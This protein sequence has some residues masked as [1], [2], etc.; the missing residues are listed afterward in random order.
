MFRQL[1]LWR[2]AMKRTIGILVLVLA[3]AGNA[4][5]QEAPA[6]LVAKVKQ[7]LARILSVDADKIEIAGVGK[8]RW[9]DTSL[10]YQEKGLSYRQVITRGFVLALKIGEVRFTYHTSYS[11]FKIVS[12]K[13]RLSRQEREKEALER[14]RAHMKKQEKKP[15]PKTEIDLKKI[16]DMVQKLSS[17]E[18]KKR[19]EAEKSLLEL[20]EKGSRDENLK[21]LRD[22][23]KKVTD[24]EARVRLGR[25]IKKL[26]VKG[27]GCIY[28]VG[29]IKDIRHKQIFSMDLD[30]SNVRQVTSDTDVK[31]MCA[32]SP[33]GARMAY[34]A[35][36]K[37]GNYD[38]L[39]MNIKTGQT[40]NLTNSRFSDCSPS[41]S[42]DGKKILLSSDRTGDH[43]V[44]VMD[45]DG[46]KLKR[47]TNRLG[48]HEAGAAYSPN[49]K[50]IVFESYQKTETKRV[51]PRHV[52]VH[53]KHE[54]WV[55]D[56]DGKN[57][58][59]LSKGNGNDWACSWSP[60]GKKML[61][62]TDRDGNSEIYLMDVKSGKEE[63]ITRNPLNDAL[64][65]A[66]WS[67]DGKNMVFQRVQNNGQRS[68]EI[69]IYNFETKKET[70]LTD[71][72]LWDGY[73]VWSMGST[74]KV[75][76]RAEDK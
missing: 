72:L 27:L 8:A 4:G 25:I 57:L 5:A 76:S 73:P 68:S 22:V 55:M 2:R 62:A 67:P 48:T 54:I 3:I 47:L 29:A 50:Q 49:G 6:G 14:W 9:G 32:V 7:D 46:S 63:R 24:T 52:E 65:P 59:K 45:A 71:N 44:Y 28:F 11:N 1:F 74:D 66:P 41:W 12:S 30:G 36:S 21:M 26:Q 20:V 64:S 58:K 10:G 34:Q 40:K 17:P 61:F 70:K 53:Y 33:D 31:M 69:W 37:N 43:E 42:P 18:W 16:K 23:L 38:I 56:A 60:D 19:E 35:L 39:V 75:K 13:P 51:G 15:E